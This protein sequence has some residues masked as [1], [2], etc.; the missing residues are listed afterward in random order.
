MKWSEENGYL[1]SVNRFS[2]Q[3]TLAR[4]LLQVAQL[5]DAADHHPDVEIRKAFELKLLLKTHS[6]GKI[7][8]K[9]YALAEQIGEIKEVD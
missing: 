7:T 6:E 5:A 1:I 9:D 2:S 8:A 3:T 4:F